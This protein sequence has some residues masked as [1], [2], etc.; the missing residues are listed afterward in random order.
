MKKLPVFFYVICLAVM[1]INPLTAAELSRTSTE[2]EDVSEPYEAD[3]YILFSD[4]VFQGP[5]YTNSDH[6]DSIDSIISCNDFE[7]LRFDIL[8][9]Q[10]ASYDKKYFYAV[11]LLYANNEE[12]YLYYYP[13]SKTLWYEEVTDGIVTYSYELDD[14]D[15]SYAGVTTPGDIPD[16]DVFFILYKDDFFD[17]EYLED[18]YTTASFFCGYEENGTLLI[19]E[20][21]AEVDIW[22]YR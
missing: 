3:E 7:F 6:L 18:Y 21:T 14:E 4:E 17:G 12:S 16:S 22:F 10:S 15:Y 19:D 9:E 13:G 2:V 11:K 5:N 20:Q 1:S 8:L